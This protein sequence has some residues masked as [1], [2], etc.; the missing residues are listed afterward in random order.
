MNKCK[1]C[2]TEFEGKFCPECGEPRQEEQEEKA[3]PVCGALTKSGAKFCSECGYSFVKQ[4][5]RK[6]AEEPAPAPAPVA[7]VAPVAPA[8]A[9][10]PAPVASA[11]V[12][13]VRPSNVL[14]T[15]Y[16][17]V[18]YVPEL[19]FFLMSVLA[20][21]FLAA[22]VTSISAAGQFL[23]VMDFGNAYRVVSLNIDGAGGL[24]DP[25]IALIV[26]AALGTAV[27]FACTIAAWRER[28]S[29]RGSFLA[30]AFYLAYLI[31]GSVMIAN[32]ASLDEGLGVLGAGA[33]PICF[34]VFAIVFALLHVVS[35]FVCKSLRRNEEVV[36]AFKAAKE[37]KEARLKA[38]Y[39]THKPP[40]LK[41]PH[42]KRSAVV[43]MYTKR[44][45]DQGRA[46]TP[47]SARV[48]FYMHRVLLGITGAAL[49]AGVVLMAT[50][51][52]YF[53]NRFRL[54]VVERISLGDKKSAVVKVL[55]EPYGGD[56]ASNDW[57]YYDDDLLAYTE[58]AQTLA[59]QQ[60]E[61]I[62]QGNFTKAE[63]LAQEA[64]NLQEQM[65]NGEFK[66]I[67]IT[68]ADEKV[69]S[70][71]FDTCYSM[72]P[73]AKETESYE[74]LGDVLVGYY[75]DET[76][77]PSKKVYVE[78][79]KANSVAYSVHFT[80]GSYYNTYVQ[81]GSLGVKT[82][83]FRTVQ[84]TYSWSDKYNTYSVNLSEEQLDKVSIGAVDKDGVWDSYGT[85]I[86]KVN[87]SRFVLPDSVT[88]VNDLAL[89]SFKNLSYN[90]YGNALYLGT[91]S[92]PYLVL[93]KATDTSITECTVHADTKII[94]SRAF[95]DCASLTSIVIPSGVKEIQTYAV[96]WCQQLTDITIPDSVTSI[97][98]R[99][100]DGC[101]GLTSIHYSGTVSTW[102]TMKKSDKW[103][104]YTGEYTVICTD[105]T[106][107]KD[108]TVS[109]T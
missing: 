105:G 51:I 95:Y 60:E 49:I 53:N 76:V 12:V 31:T 63:Q 78:G 100:F 22:P 38:F 8:P 29:T 35:I 46:K 20:F 15:V 55:G 70:V 107:A 93:V 106:I 16:R 80:D 89:S 67:E 65:Q 36:E 84:Y 37:A 34:L 9:P 1:K 41:E 3:C 102:Q 10:A 7:P 23:G 19:L 54:G 52:P 90:P 75:T 104:G 64:K 86:E 13:A 18:K 50:L 28:G 98:T 62:A 59:K 79:T 40:V 47:S 109:Y 108:G 103:D 39:A 77:S 58:R 21:A 91:S 30:F 92:N 44:Y 85:G 68:F 101:T 33:C 96:Y 57:F 81:N 71:F 83:D 74:L 2:G 6:T 87:P 25:A 99:A 45:Y 42:T 88:S 69:S 61:A 17:V 48:F 14:Y 32:T 43:Y 97:G 73:Q 82:V 24:R 56:R 27:S 5:P 11:P 72:T 4:E 26:F 66:C 94:Y